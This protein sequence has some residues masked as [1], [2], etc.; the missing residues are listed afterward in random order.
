MSNSIRQLLN[1]E[2]PWRKPV[3]LVI[4]NFYYPTQLDSPDLF[5]KDHESA[6][7]AIEKTCSLIDQDG[8]VLFPGPLDDIFLMYDCPISYNEIGLPL[9]MGNAINDEQDIKKF[10]IKGISEKRL[11]LIDELLYLKQNLFVT[12][13]VPSPFELACILRGINNAYKDLLR[14][15]VF[16]KSLVDF[17]LQWS[18]LMAESYIKVGVENITIKNS[19]GSC[20]MIAPKSYQEFAFEA[21]KSLV[22]F[23]HDLNATATLHVCRYSEP[24]VDLMC[25]TGADIVEI[26]S[27]IIF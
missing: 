8:V 7:R 4:E 26:D 19:L 21:D 9:F 22:K 6:K 11:K 25:T 18:K 12:V 27:P 5:S 13:P 2:K 24:I 23:I 20:S 10:K 17:C 14:N 15:S 16:I 3:F 1:H